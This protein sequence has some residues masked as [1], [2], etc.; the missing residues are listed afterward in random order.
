MSV[1]PDPTRAGRGRGPG[2]GP[3]VPS[4]LLSPVCPSVT[5]L[6]RSLKNLTTPT[7]AAADAARSRSSLKI[8]APKHSFRA[9]ITRA[10]IAVYVQNRS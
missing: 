2:G 4:S 8:V 5:M 10:V 1:P 9:D 3:G 6:C 7:A